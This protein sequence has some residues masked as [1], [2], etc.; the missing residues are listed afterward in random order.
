MNRA[1]TPSDKE[2]RNALKIVAALEQG[3]KQHTGVVVVDGSM[4]DKPVEIRARTVL[5]QARAAGLLGKE[6][7]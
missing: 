6:R 3:A 2:I 5:D 1:F 4:V 7:L